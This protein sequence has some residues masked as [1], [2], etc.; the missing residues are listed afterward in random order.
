MLDGGTPSLA[1]QLASGG[2]RRYASTS[3][4]ARRRRDARLGDGRDVPRR[5]PRARA[6]GR[7][8]LEP[9]AAAAAEVDDQPRR[10]RAHVADSREMT[11]G[12]ART[13]PRESGPRGELERRA[14]R[15][16]PRRRP[17]PAADRA[18]PRVEA[19]SWRSWARRCA[20]PLELFGRTL[21]AAIDSTPRSATE[22]A[23]IDAPYAL[24]AVSV[25]RGP[26]RVKLVLE[27]RPWRRSRSRW[28]SERS[29]GSPARPGLVGRARIACSSLRVASVIA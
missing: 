1:P 14:V 26:V 20:E 4:C 18:P 13:W 25:E 2:S 9:L 29:R 3:A 19:A 5:P 22:K 12:R 6:P 8:Q 23:R 16:G 17:G 21:C 7:E 24:V 11:V 27:P 10:A 15:A 28:R